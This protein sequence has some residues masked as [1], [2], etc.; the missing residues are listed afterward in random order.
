MGRGELDLEHIEFN[1]NFQLGFADK[2]RVRIGAHDINQIRKYFDDKGYT[3]DILSE[4][5]E[6]YGVGIGPRCFEYYAIFSKKPGS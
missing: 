4:S 6:N 1:V 2:V 5:T 3:V